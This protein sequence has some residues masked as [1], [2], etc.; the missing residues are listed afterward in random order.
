MAQQRRRGANARRPGA[1]WRG[2]SSAQWIGSGRLGSDPSR[3]RL[4]ADYTVKEAGA[5]LKLEEGRWR[6]RNKYDARSWIG[7]G[8]GR[9][10][11]RRQWDGG[12]EVKVGGR[13]AR[14][15]LYRAWCTVNSRLGRR[16]KFKNISFFNLTDEFNFKM[17]V[18]IY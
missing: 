3:R 1:T 4:G 13:S 5:L 14:L 17:S 16:I 8:K 11:S 12:E 7:W 15:G 18:L 10:G 9:E 2:G 6:S